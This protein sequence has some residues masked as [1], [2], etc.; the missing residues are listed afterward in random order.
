[1]SEEFRQRQVQ[2]VTA[3]GLHRLAYTE[4]GDPA[5][6]KVLICAHGLSRCGRDLP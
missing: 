5:G 3:S 1:M 4:W 6:R 2:C